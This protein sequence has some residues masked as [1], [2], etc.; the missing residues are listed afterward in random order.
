MLKFLNC[1][2]G[3]L[4]KILLVFN[5]MSSCLAWWGLLRSF[6]NSDDWVED[7]SFV[8]LYDVAS[9]YHFVDYKM[10]LLYVKHYLRQKYFVIKLAKHKGSLLSLESW[11]S[12]KS[13]NSNAK[14]KL[15]NIRWIL[16][17]IFKP[18]RAKS[19]QTKIFDF[20]FH[21]NGRQRTC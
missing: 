2:N 9:H 13:F 14:K 5:V 4:M 21:V 19:Q 12:I 1:D 3:T 10:R 18:D 8:C 11:H 7:V 15:V 6:N 16:L 20:Q 17:L